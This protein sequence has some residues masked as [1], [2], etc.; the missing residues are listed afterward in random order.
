MEVTRLATKAVWEIGGAIVN[1]YN[2]ST[3]RENYASN[4]KTSRLK[5]EEAMSE[6][7]A[8]RAAS[9]GKD[10]PE[11]NK[12][13]VV[14]WVNPSLANTYINDCIELRNDSRKDLTTCSLFVKLTGTNAGN[15]TTEND[16][17]FHFV[18]YWPAGESRYLWYPSKSKRGV[19]TDESVDVITDV[20][21]VV[22][23][24]QIE[25]KASFKFAGKKYDD[26][27]ES[28]ANENL[29]PADFGGRWYNDADNLF[30]P[31]GFNVTYNGKMSTF[32]VKQILVRATNG[33]RSETIR[34]TKYYWNSGET[35]WICHKNFNTVYPKKVEVI[36]TFPGSSYEHVMVWNR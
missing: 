19:A 30:D 29:K 1:A 20:D 17:H 7:A 25:T 31:A 4:Y 28:W 5:N 2:L 32:N 33:N 13:V 26:Y 15:G 3:E 21:V 18:S 14:A 35:K 9:P 8:R 16:N 12:A 23:S 22:I 36:I 34:H 24:D 10:K 6:L 11:A 27:I